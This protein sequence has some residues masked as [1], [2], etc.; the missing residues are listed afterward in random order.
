MQT[1]QVQKVLDFCIGAGASDARI[2][3]TVS[4]QTAVSLYNRDVDKIHDASDCSVF[5]QLFVDG[6]YGTF[7]T[8]MLDDASLREFIS[9]AVRLTR[10]L[11][12]DECRHLAPA[13]LCF[14]GGGDLKLLDPAAGNVTAELGKALAV[15]MAESLCAHIDGGPLQS[16]ETEFGCSVEHEVLADTAGFCQTRDASFYTLSAGCSFL[17]K[18]GS[19]PQSWWPDANV[20]FSKLSAARCAET[21]YNRGMAR[22]GA[23]RIDAGRYDVV[24]ENGS[25]AKFVSP[26]LSALSGSALQQNNSFLLDSLGKKLF[27]SRLTIIDNPH[28]PSTY[29]ARFYDGEGLAT[30]KCSVVDEGVVNRYFL[31][32]YYAD[33]L[34]MQ[35][36]VDS[37]SVVEMVPDAGGMDDQIK[38]LDRGVLI[39]GFNGGNHNPITGD[40]S[41]GIEGFWFENGR[42]Q[43]PIH[44]MNVTGNYLDL[45]NRLAAVGNDP[46]TLF[47]MQLPSVSFE[48]LSLT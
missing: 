20:F 15:Q 13:E 39:T 37:V 19:R 16:C 30:V 22:L 43:F 23:R 45:W 4:D 32:S 2:I 14:K 33:K 28:K 42:K 27:S 35:P 48:G 47:S 7:S 18:D 6:R 1:N 9:N 5:L 36:T 8:N 31:T 11:E 44:E 12:K 24:V 10:L 26:L 34:H 25:V 17:D 3:F 21:A 46:L 29:G 41:Y 40:F 38:D